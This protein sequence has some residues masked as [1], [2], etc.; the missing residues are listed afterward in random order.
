MKKSILTI[1]FTSLA[2]IGL[3]HIALAHDDEED[4]DQPVY[5]QQ[6]DYG[7]QPVYQ[8]YR[9][10]DQYDRQEGGSRIDYEVDHLNRMVRHVQQELRRYRANWQVRRQYQHLQAEAY[11]LNAQFRRGEQYYNRGR[12][13]AQIEHMHGE[14]HQIEQDLH[15]PVTAYFQWR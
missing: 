3:S 15:V 9:G 1:A 12:L 2:L 13:L 6:P 11:Q 14:L 8:S 10:N 7:Q 5:R 4:Q